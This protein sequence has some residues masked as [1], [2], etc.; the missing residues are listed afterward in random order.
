[1]CRKLFFL[2]SLVLVLALTGSASAS[3]AYTWDNNDPANDYWCTPGNWD[4]DGNVPD[5]PPGIAAPCDTVTIPGDLEDGPTHM[6]GCDPNV[7][8]IN[9][10]NPAADK[11][12]VVDITGNLIVQDRWSWFDDSGG[13]QATINIT[14]NANLSILGDAGD[15]SFRGPDNGSGYVNISGDP[16]IYVEGMFRG[17]D[18]TNSYYRFTMSGGDVNCGGL[19][20]GDDGQGDFYLTGGTIYCRN[21]FEITGRQMSWFEVL[22]DGGAEIIIN[23]PYEAPANDDGQAVINLDDGYIE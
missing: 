16:T 13:G 20:I 8:S 21:R 1:M 14:G 15:H 11:H 18:K 17:A 10:P 3:E 12:V 9:G 5:D 22:I 7:F 4:V 2:T 6:I 19:K 23:G